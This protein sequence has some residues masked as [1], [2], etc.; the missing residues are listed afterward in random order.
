MGASMWEMTMSNGDIL[1]FYSNMTYVENIFGVGQRTGTWSVEEGI[2]IID[3]TFSQADK[4]TITL[5]FASLP[6]NGVSVTVNKTHPRETITATISSVEALT[7]D[8]IP[9]YSATINMIAGKQLDVGDGT[10]IY[11]FQNMTTVQNVVTQGSGTWSIANGVLIQDI[12]TFDPDQG[13]ETTA[14]VFDGPVDED[15]NVTIDVY[16]T[17]SN[18]DNNDSVHVTLNLPVV[19]TDIPVDASYCSSFDNNP[20]P[21]N[22]KISEIKGKII[23]LTSNDEVLSFFDNMTCRVTGTD[24][25][26]G[27]PYD[28]AG[29]WSIENG[30]LI[31]DVTYP[32]SESENRAYV[33]NAKPSAGSTLTAY[34]TLAADPVKDENEVIVSI[35]DIPQE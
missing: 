7:D 30:V 13:T 26:D 17:Y 12:T 15:G 28:I 35:V 33:F 11:F 4:E 16:E 9:S 14:I 1:S 20:V 10:I 25:D 8:I 27:N 29:T 34:L 32:D 19:L 2:L 6:A 5:E 23:T 22:V 21:Y 24:A 3:V 31:V 18:G